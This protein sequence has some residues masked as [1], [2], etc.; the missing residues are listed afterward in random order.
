[1]TDGEFIHARIGEAIAAHRRRIGHL[2]TLAALATR[3][4]DL[5]A[6]L[7]RLGATRG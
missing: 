5:E 3:L 6:R 2:R 7:E 4:D 1:M